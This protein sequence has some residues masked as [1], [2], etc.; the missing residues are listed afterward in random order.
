MTFRTAQAM[1]FGCLVVALA[2]TSVAL[3]VGYVARQYFA[4][5]LQ[6]LVLQALAQFSGPLSVVIGSFFALRHVTPRPRVAL[7]GSILALACVLIWGL[8][9]AG[10]T[11]AFIASADELNTALT[12]WFAQVVTSASFLV[13]GVLAYFFTSA[14]KPNQ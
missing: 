13:T 10:R 4:D 5:D 7:S 14:A 6:A 2:T 9:T 12:N 8:L 3:S 1:I 11:V